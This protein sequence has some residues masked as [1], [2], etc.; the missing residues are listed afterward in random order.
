MTCAFDEQDGWASELRIASSGW[1]ASFLVHFVA[2]LLLGLITFSARP[3]GGPLHLLAV[4]G[5]SDAPPAT[6][7][8][9]P[10]TIEPNLPK[11]DSLKDTAIV[12]EPLKVPTDETKGV[13]RAETPDKITTIRPLPPGNPDKGGEA[14]KSIADA[15]RRRL[16]RPQSRRASRSDRRRARQWI[17]RERRGRRTRAAMAGRASTQRWQLVLRSVGPAV[18]RDVRQL[19]LGA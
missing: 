16:G 3:G 8:K 14:S 13:L 19:G 1:F 11:G 7:D 15:D 9:Q 6:I 18:Q 17:E 10:W 5:D 12:A 4:G 2:L